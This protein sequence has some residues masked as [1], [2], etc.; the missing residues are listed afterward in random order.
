MASLLDR[1]SASITACSR[2][3]SRGGRGLCKGV[4]ALVASLA[5]FDSTTHLHTLQHHGFKPLSMKRKR[6]TERVHRDNKRQKSSHGC[7]EP[8]AW[9]LLR[10]YYPEVL[11]LRR[12]LASKLTSTSK[13][14]RKRLLQYGLDNGSGSEFDADLSRLLDGI[15]VGTFDHAHQNDGNADLDKDISVFTQQVSE[16]LASIGP[17]QGALKQNE[18]GKAHAPYILCFDSRNI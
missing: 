1:C 12:H 3:E 15:A 5:C 4:M 2:T 16:S 14:R 18:V 9:A 10:Q 7:K 8:P 17:T 13:N 6:K 11:T